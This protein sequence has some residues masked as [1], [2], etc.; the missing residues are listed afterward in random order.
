M[1]SG[2]TS[3][4]ST[5][6]SVA[7]VSSTTAAASPSPTPFFEGKSVSDLQNVLG[8]D[9]MLVPAYLVTDPTSSSSA[10]ASSVNAPAAASAPT[11]HNN[12]PLVCIFQIFFQQ[13]L[14]MVALCVLQPCKMSQTRAIEITKKRRPSED[15]DEGTPCC[16]CRVQIAYHGLLLV[17]FGYLSVI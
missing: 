15:V 11:T 17:C 6:S 1:A 7:A 4:G 8:T 14:T 16:V 13:L 12:N 10:V 3:A 5:S 9:M 2:S